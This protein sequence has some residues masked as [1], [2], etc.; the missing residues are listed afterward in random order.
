MKKFNSL[1]SQQQGYLFTVITMC[2]WGSFSLLA[3]MNAYWH[4]Q[5]WD[6]LLLRFSIATLVLLPILYLKKD[7]RFLWDWRM[8]VLALTGSIGYC[9]FVYSGFFH[10][11]V[12]HGIVFLNGTFPLFAALI[13]YL[14]LGQ[15]IDRQTGIGLAVIILTLA[16]MVVMMAN[17]SGS[18][19][20]GDAMFIAS[21]ICWGLFS[22]LLRKWSFSA[23]HIMC[24]VAIWSSVIY[25]PWYW[26]F[27]T[28]AFDAATPAHLAIQGVFH[29]IFVVIIATLTYAKAVA[30][31]GVFKAGS[32]ANLAPFIA[33]LAAVP[34][35]GETLN[36]TLAFGL[37]GMALGAL[38]PWRWFIQ[39]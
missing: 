4:I 8:L 38:Q 3:R 25:L 36:P 29:G 28:P 11:P 26:L 21:G 24:G 5:V 31:I 33:S 16:V 7:Y 34:L 13:G 15:T 12:A 9:V 32:I 10:A 37:F 39:R 19:G 30:Q 17:G 27:V 23:W 18:F 20:I 6:I 2:I 1:S 14:A 22:V 35:L